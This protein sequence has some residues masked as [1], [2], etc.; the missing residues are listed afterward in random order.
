MKVYSLYFLIIIFF[1]SAKNHLKA[2]S[3]NVFSDS[4]KNEIL[5]MNKKVDE[6]QLNLG[7]SYKKSKWGIIT[8]TLGYSITIA[9]GQMLGG[10]NNDLGE[11]FLYLGGAVGVAGTAIL[12]DSFNDI[13]RAAGIR[14]KKRR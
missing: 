6:I 12:V 4:I 1:L 7:K 2:Q 5:L 8:A 3:T 14:K 11:A 13:G 9:G 10:R